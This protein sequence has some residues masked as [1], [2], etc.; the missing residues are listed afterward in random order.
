MID[1]GGQCLVALGPSADRLRAAAH[2][3]AA[4]VHRVVELALGQHEAVDDRGRQA[5]LCRDS[6]CDP[7]AGRDMDVEVLP[8]PRMDDGKHERT[9]GIEAEVADERLVEDGVD[10]RCVVGDPA[11]VP[12]GGRARGGRQLVHPTKTTPPA[13]S[14]RGP[15]GGAQVAF[16]SIPHGLPP[17]PKRWAL[18]P[19]ILDRDSEMPWGPRTPRGRLRAVRSPIARVLVR[20]E[21]AWEGAET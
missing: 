14:R 13:R 15:A 19:E 11:R 21:G 7:R 18:A 3:H 5:D 20:T 16:A 4:V 1:D 2:H 6:P 10:Q 9:V 12:M 17:S 8:D